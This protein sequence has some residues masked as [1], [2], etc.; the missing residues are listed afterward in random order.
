MRQARFLYRGS[1]II[2]A[3]KMLKEQDTNSDFSSSEEAISSFHRDLTANLSV[4]HVS[5]LDDHR[6]NIITLLREERPGRLYLS[7]E[8]LSFEEQEIIKDEA[9]EFYQGASMEDVDGFLTALRVKILS[10]NNVII[11]TTKSN[12]DFQGA[13]Q[14]FLSKQFKIRF[15]QT[16]HVDEDAL[17]DEV[18]LRFCSVALTGSK[19]II[20]FNNPSKAFQAS[21]KVMR[22][23]QQLQEELEGVKGPRNFEKYLG[24]LAGQNTP[25]H[26]WSIPH[27]PYE[28]RNLILERMG[29]ALSYYFSFAN[30][31]MGRP[32]PD[33][34]VHLLKYCGYEVDIRQAN[35]LLSKLDNKEI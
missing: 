6:N 31:K 16:G 33:V 27:T 26:L 34:L 5:K 7:A 32:Y 18:F 2:H 11:E 10:R 29:K 28:K 21:P 22:L 24:E 14:K 25:S 19:L 35:R 3:F 9:I 12:S 30:T 1:A 13:Y 20:G 15:T 23:A 17:S 4:R 8:E